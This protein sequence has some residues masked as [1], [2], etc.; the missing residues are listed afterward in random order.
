M[1]SITIDTEASVRRLLGDAVQIPAAKLE[2]II[3]Q[4]AAKGYCPFV[5]NGV[6]YCLGRYK[7]GREGF[8]LEDVTAPEPPADEDHGDGCDCRECYRR[9]NGEYPA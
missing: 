6:N 5:V 1:A 9:V 4:V 8:T 2:Y 7:D 3:S